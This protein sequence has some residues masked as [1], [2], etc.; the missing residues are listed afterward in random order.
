MSSNSSKCGVFL[1]LTGKASLICPNIRSFFQVTGIS[2]LILAFTSITIPPIFT[3]QPA[4]LKQIGKEMM[5]CR[6]S[7]KSVDPVAHTVFLY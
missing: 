5:I 7:V 4:D 3:S 2:P 1:C 6:I